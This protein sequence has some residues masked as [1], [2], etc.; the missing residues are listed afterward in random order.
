MDNTND[1]NKNMNSM[2]DDDIINDEQFEDMRD[3]L[4]EDFL[5]LIQIY[6]NDSK[7]RIITLRHALANNDNAAG[8]EAAHALK[9]AS[10][11][12]GTTTVMVLSGQLQ[13]SCR[14][15]TIHAQIALINTL[16]TALEQAEKEIN[17]RMEP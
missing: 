7:Q 16:S 9:G 15:N 6:F 3:L 12:L 17:R 10:A 13:E 14:D 5:D 4:E 1:N 2:A 11:N 8:F